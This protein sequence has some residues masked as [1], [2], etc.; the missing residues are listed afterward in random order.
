MSG[1]PSLPPLFAARMRAQLG[2]EA[3]AYFNALE[4]PPVRGIRL[5]PRKPVKGLEALVGG[6]GGPVPWWPG[7]GRY[8]PLDSPAGLDPLHE[9]GAYYLQEPSAMAAVAV[10]APRPG[11]RVLDLCA[12]P[13][14]KSTQI[15]DCLQGRGLLVANEPVPGRA[16]VLSRNLERMGV[17]NALVV[18]ADP[19]RLCGLWP[20]LFDAVLV[21][22]PCSGEGMF[23]RH[24]ETRAEWS[25][26]SAAGC[27][28][29]QGRILSCACAMLKPGG[30]LAYSTCTLNP[31]ENEQAICRL[32]QHDPQMEAVPFSLAL[33]GAEKISAPDGTL[34]LYPHRVQGEGHFVAL[35]RKRGGAVGPAARL[36]P[37]ARSLQAPGIALLDA[38][39]GFAERFGA[40]LPAA[41]AC[42]GNELL[43]APELPA[44]DGV[45]VLRAGVHLGGVKGKAFEPGHA[46]ALAL[47]QPLPG[48]ALELDRRGALAYQRGETL[49]VPDAWKGYALAAY[50]GLALGFGKASGGQLKNHY[51]KG[52]RRP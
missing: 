12:A 28:A 17:A 9:A 10:L 43:S 51:P 25:A 7:T 16:R 15:A 29:R 39:R 2:G 34:R 21:D 48:P 41:N 23:R 14:G 22:A 47:P 33:G 45:R 32:L 27:A 49:P 18:S 40:A 13:G 6:M 26:A 8:L 46:L 36:L 1:P 5:N 35:L 4:R 44:L 52:L 30:R 11:E 37:A 20:L 19:E 3:E 50:H 38:Y 24:P 31:E 42:L